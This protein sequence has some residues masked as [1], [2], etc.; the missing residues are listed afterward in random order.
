MQGAGTDRRPPAGRAPA[1]PRRRRS[2]RCCRHAGAARRPAGGRPR[3]SRSNGTPVSG[4]RLLDLIPR[5]HGPPDR[6]DVRRGARR[7]RDRRR[8]ARRRRPARPGRGRPLGARSRGV[9][10][11]GDRLFFPRLVT[12]EGARARS[13]AR[14]GSR[15]CRPRR[16]T[17]ARRLRLHSRPDQ[18]VARAPQPAAAAAARR[19]P[20]RVLDRRGRARPCDGARASTSA[21]P[22][23]ASRSC[24]SFRDRLVERRRTADHDC[25]DGELAADQRGRR[26]DRRRR[27][28]R[29]PVD[30]AHEDARRRGDDGADRR[31]G[32]GRLRD[33][34]RRRP[35][36]RGRGG[37]RRGSS[38]SRRSR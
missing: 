22:S 16:S 7:C 36:D 27:A 26:R 24:S 25:A 18:P 13:R 17:R 4:R 38:A 19:R 37:A 12:G 11:Q 3:R 31:A 14:S 34:P 35:E 1:T 5:S 29:R 15:G 6:A 20:H 23:S 33:R 30:D 2:K 10:T 21:S 28:R 9:V 8:L 32:V